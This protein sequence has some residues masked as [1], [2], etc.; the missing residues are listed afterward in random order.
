MFGLGFGEVLVILVVALLVFGPERLPEL[1]RTL[2]KTMAELR[3]AMDEVKTEFRAPIQDF[4]RSMRHTAPTGDTQPPSQSAALQAPPQALP[5]GMQ[6]N[7]SIPTAAADA[8]PVGAVPGAA[9]AQPALSPEH[10]N[11]SAAG[12]SETEVKSQEQSSGTTAPQAPSTE[13]KN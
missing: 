1:A 10:P 4:E 13:E 12:H 8:V 6:E 11:T 5:Q 3:R 2:G 7:A 9:A